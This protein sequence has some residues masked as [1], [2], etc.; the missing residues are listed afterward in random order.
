[1]TEGIDAAEVAGSWR[2]IRAQGRAGEL[3]GQGEMSRSRVIRLCDVSARAIVLGSAQPVGDLDDER[4]AESGL[5][6]CRRRSGGGAVVV[7]PGG[8]VWLDVFVPAADPLWNSDVSKSVWWLGECARRAVASLTGASG[9]VRSGPM[10]KSRWS[11]MICFA[12]LGPGELQIAG[13]KVLGISQRRERVGTWLFVALLLGSGAQAALAEVVALGDEDRRDV[14]GQ[15]HATVSG[16][17]ADRSSA[18]QALLAEL[19]LV[20]PAT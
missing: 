17:D 3:V 9:E 18:E 5:E 8:Q 15:L 20:S 4:V 6:V 10:L 11:A 16:V 14:A 12:G 19:A 1:M 13:R 2:I 7:Q